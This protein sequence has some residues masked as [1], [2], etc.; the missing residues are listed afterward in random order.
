MAFSQEEQ[1]LIERLEA[2]RQRR[3]T[4]LLML[5]SVANDKEFKSLVAEKNKIAAKTNLSPEEKAAR[6]AEI[7]EQMNR[8]YQQHT[9]ES[10]EAMAFWQQVILI[11]ESNEL[12]KAKDQN[13]KTIKNTKPKRDQIRQSIVDTGLLSQAFEGLENYID[14]N[15]PL[16]FSTLPNQAE[17]REE[18]LENTTQLVLSELKKDYVLRIKGVDA[19]NPNISPGDEFSIEFLFQ[20]L[21]FLDAAGNLRAGLNVTSDAHQQSIDTFLTQNSHTRFYSPA[22]FNLITAIENY[23]EDL[24]QIKANTSFD[25]TAKQRKIAEKLTELTEYLASDKV[26]AANFEEFADEIYDKR[27]E[28]KLSKLLEPITPP[29]P[30]APPESLTRI[31]E[32][33]TECLVDSKKAQNDDVMAQAESSEMN[34]IKK[35]TQDI[36]LQYHLARR[37][38][39]RQEHPATYDREVES[40]PNQNGYTKTLINLATNNQITLHFNH[41]DQLTQV[42]MPPILSRGAWL[43]NKVVSKFKGVED[44][45]AIRR[46]D[47][48]C[49]FDYLEDNRIYMGNN[50]YVYQGSAKDGYRYSADVLKEMVR[51]YDDVKSR[52]E[53]AKG[54]DK[55]VAEI[56]KTANKAVQKTVEKKLKEAAPEMLQDI[57]PKR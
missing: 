15:T 26:R 3:H 12:L 22:H 14:I 52:N 57:K 37:E 8:R 46:N 33:V 10:R 45:D 35:F 17:V 34:K 43:R 41:E 25:P 23:L 4:Q 13:L 54:V 16:N 56:K 21:P 19:N 11:N 28:N 6:L 38:R 30:R 36:N 55:K 42:I 9:M 29:N 40:I 39:E 48:K 31:K 18:I 7:D 47:L 27:F 50:W 20:E 2:K 1:A 51:H 32:A 49:L 53:F 44:S 24:K 5:E